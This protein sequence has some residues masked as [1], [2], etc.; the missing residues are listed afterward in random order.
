MHTQEEE[1][2]EFL[3]CQCK[4]G[5]FQKIQISD[6]PSNKAGDYHTLRFTFHNSSHIEG[7]RTPSKCFELLNLFII[8]AQF[9]S[10]YTDETATD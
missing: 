2:V 5:S 8:R 10:S 1:K 4:T 9:P 7:K 6:L 3:L